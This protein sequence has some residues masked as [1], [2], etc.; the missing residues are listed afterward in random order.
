MSRREVVLGAL[1]CVG[2]K[3]KKNLSKKYTGSE[4][5]SREESIGETRE[6]RVCE[7]RGIRPKEINT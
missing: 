6:R 3:C 1:L 7:M 4:R 2:G 5:A